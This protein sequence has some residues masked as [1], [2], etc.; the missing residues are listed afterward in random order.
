MIVLLRANGIQGDSR[1]DKYIKSLDKSSIDYH[2]V[3]WDRLNEG[4]T[5]PKTSF[6]KLSS[7][8]NL[9]GYKAA[10]GRLRWFWYVL[11]KLIQL[12]PSVIHACDLDCA[13]PAA[14]Y[15]LLYPSKYLIFDVFDW[16]S[17]TLYN[18]NKWL[19]RCFAMLE[20]FTTKKSDHIIIC[21]KE[22][23]KQIPYDIDHK[24]SILPN[25]PM[26]SE[27]SKIQKAEYGF[28]NNLITIA[29]VG[30]FY[31]ERFLIE[32]TELAEIG[33]INLLMAGYG[34]SKI[35]NAIL[36]IADLPNVKYFG[37][38]SYGEGLS[39][40]KSA[41]AIYAMYCTSNPNN[42][43][44]APNKFYESLLLGKPVITTKGTTIGDKVAKYKTGYVIQEDW[45]QLS[46]LISNIQDNKSKN[47]ELGNNAR[48]LW[49]NK[50]REYVRSY[51][52]KIYLPMI[53]EHA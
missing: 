10:L 11:R 48:N 2:I 16:F 3:G 29:Y 32:L 45:L 53:C 35:T 4:L 49:I 15:K 19:V 41:D 46:N 50:Y 8:Y 7:G 47:D 42:V 28:S 12:K 36:N 40:M 20:K 14:I 37:K 51:M 30:A 34:D 43:C 44:A 31:D 5:L 13:F 25:I 6:Y 9:G 23:R 21:E 1:V 38:V 33:K 26:I 52:D 39:I 17:A 22:R 27:E 18:Q 24:M